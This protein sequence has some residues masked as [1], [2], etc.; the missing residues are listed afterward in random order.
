LIQPDEED[1]LTLC[2]LT[3]TY[4]VEKRE[5]EGTTLAPIMNMH[6]AVDIPIDHSCA[7]I[8]DDVNWKDGLII[9]AG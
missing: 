8:L 7:M 4:I 1:S 6:G 9:H 5:A 2:Y 3:V